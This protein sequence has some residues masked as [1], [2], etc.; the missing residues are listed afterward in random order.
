MR[1]QLPGNH[2]PSLRVA[3][4]TVFMVMLI[5][6]APELAKAADADL[7]TPVDQPSSAELRN[8][9]NSVLQALV[10]DPSSM[11]IRLLQVRVERLKKNT[12]SLALQIDPATTTIF[13]KVSVEPGPKNA[14]TWRGAHGDGS[15]NQAY[16]T[17]HGKNI[18]GTIMLEGRQFRLEPLG[19]GSHALVQMDTNR[20]SEG[21]DEVETPVTAPPIPSEPGTDTTSIHTVRVLTVLTH[22]AY[23]VLADPQASVTN[24][25]AIAN[26]GLQNSRINLRFENAGVVALD[27]REPEGMGFDEMLKK[28]RNTND[29]DIGLAASH[30][31]ESTRADLVSLL[32]VHPKNRGLA[33]TNATKSYGFSV[34]YA[35]ALPNHTLAHEL[36]HNLGA[37]HDPDQ[38]TTPTVPAYAHG[39]R[40][41]GKW[42]SVMSYAC[43][44]GQS[45]PR[46]N[47][48]SNP[49][50]TYDG[51]PMGTADKNN[52]ARVLRDNAARVAAFYPD[53]DK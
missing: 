50:L 43:T 13:D 21:K 30:H 44:T 49:D 36:G 26:L 28:L 27:W 39:I 9:T 47:Y 32:A 37:R 18:V 23:A 1:I 35:L 11:D 12:K 42:S 2:Y 52:N 24:A 41:P 15:R 25:L 29:H 20:S 17:R 8:S 51:T 19:D 53:P 31:R 48:W 10:K 22:G 3:L 46:I 6:M 33:Y 40:W 14:F 38:Y 5:G 34:V 4:L 45:C 7:F 16:L